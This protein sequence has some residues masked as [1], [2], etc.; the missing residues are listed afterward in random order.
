M[1]T[2]D[3][4]LMT[5]AQSIACKVSA[6]TVLNL[7]SRERARLLEAVSDDIKKC[8]NFI[9]PEVSHAALKEARRRGVNLFSKN[10]HDQP[11]FDPGRNTFHF[12]H[13]LP[14][15]ALRDLCVEAKIDGAI[16]SLLRTR[17]RVA[18]ILKSEDRALTRLGYRSKRADPEGAYGQAMIKL[19]KQSDTG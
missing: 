4:L 3:E 18:W 2:T 10:W 6:L 5:F 12:E 17:L 15:K 8:T 16:Y 1:A 14:V 7:S 13:V 9:M 19:L 11:G